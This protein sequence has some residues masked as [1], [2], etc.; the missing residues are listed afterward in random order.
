MAAV[1]LTTWLSRT[2]ERMRGLEQRDERR[3]SLKVLVAAELLDV[4]IG[5]REA[6]ALCLAAVRT[7]EGGGR[8][9]E[10][11]D[12]SGYMPRPMP[13][14]EGAGVELLV[15][16]EK[17][18]D[19]L[20]T[21]RTN[22]R[23]TGMIMS[24]ITAGRAQFGLLKAKTLSASLSHDMTVLA[25]AFELI[26]PARKLRMEGRGPELVGVLLR[27]EANEDQE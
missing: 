18:I 17:A 7:A 13:F 4:A 20:V 15:L 11:E 21:L 25:E 6:K 27:R 2:H 1:L 22:L 19:A 26:A 3:S 8:L 23:Q 5:L 16:E 14:V 9:P 24:E 12:F 10:R